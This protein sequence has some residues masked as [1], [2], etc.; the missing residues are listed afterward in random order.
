MRREG[1]FPRILWFACD[2]VCSCNCTLISVLVGTRAGLCAVCASVP[3]PG[4]PSVPT[5]VHLLCGYL[6][7]HEYV[8]LT[9]VCAHIE[10]GVSVGSL[11][12][13]LGRE[14]GTF[15]FEGL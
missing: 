7:V 13:S 9:G 10:Q 1:W 14:P 11:S 3:G 2:Y 12:L 8:N 6:S 5:Q 4:F 15:N